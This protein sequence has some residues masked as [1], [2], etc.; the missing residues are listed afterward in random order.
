MVEFTRTKAGPSDRPGLDILRPLQGPQ[1]VDIHCHCLPNLDD[2]PQT[3]A[4]SLSLCRSLV[5]DSVTTVVATPHQ[6]GCFEGRNEADAV[7]QAVA[8][9]NGE[10]QKKSLPLQVWP[11]A[12][13][14]VDERIPALLQADRVLTLADGGR[15]ILLELPGDTIVDLRPLLEQL[16]S[17]SV[18]AIIT[19]P[20][21]NEYLIRHPQ[22]VDSWLDLN[23]HLQITAG[24]LLGV[25]GSAAEQTAW[26]FLTLGMAS[27]IATDAHDRGPR[28]PQ[29]RQAYYAIS[30][31][32]GEKTAQ[33]LCLEN[34]R[35]IL[36]GGEI[37]RPERIE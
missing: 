36:T 28:R 24:S 10:L 18:T 16:A 19:H 11:G 31:R 14:R 37:T 34:P 4:E 30:Q 23:A 26:Y 3:I 27:L 1:F 33:K 21:R 22:A 20:E 25:F 15:Y 12:D 6:L 17:M 5:A 7:R 32:L 29:M 8:I 9:L 35:G 13:V 2:G